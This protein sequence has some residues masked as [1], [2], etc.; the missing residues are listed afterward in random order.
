M[1][2]VAWCVLSCG[3]RQRQ[4][5]G[6]RPPQGG[7]EPLVSASDGEVMGAQGQSVGETL[8][9]GATQQGLAPGWE[10]EDGR[11]SYDPEAHP[12]GHSD[13]EHCSKA[14]REWPADAGWEALP[15]K[16]CGPRS[17]R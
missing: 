12:G 11:L 16:G 6:A 8:Q 14:T 13:K 2:A 3:S 4:P 10:Y 9:V 17:T 15:R 1:C 5:E 7:P